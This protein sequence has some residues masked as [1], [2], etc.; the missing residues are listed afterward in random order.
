[1]PELTM[2]EAINL[3]LKQEMAADERVYVLGEDVGVDGGI[4]RAT[5]GLIEEFG[6]DRVMDTPLAESGI[7][8]FSIGMAING[9][10]PVPEMQFS[11]FAYLGFHQIESHASRMRWRSQGRF[12][13][14]MTVRMP[15]GGGVRALEHHSE[16]RE[17][18]YAHMPGVKMVV[19]SGPRNAR[20]LLVAAIRDPDPVVFFEPKASYRA[21][22]EEVP[23]DEEVAEIGPA[24]IVQEGQDLTIVSW[25]AMSR[26]AREA[27]SQLAE[28]DVSVELIDLTSLSPLDY[29]AIAK[30]VSRTG[31]C[32]VVQEAPLTY[33]P[34][35]EIAARVGEEAFLHLKAPVARVA[36]PDVHMPYFAREQAY[37]PDAGRIVQAAEYVRQ[38]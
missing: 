29:P 28:K 27:A 26:R 18:F 19:P 23:E 2:I 30:S 1:M 21:F 4:F 20:S 16:S 3:A 15:Y 9:L 35:A 24:Q 25:G 5:Q 17:A 14:P 37:L 8:G 11:G 13:I 22:R 7:L 10:R 33:G 6:E 34:A 12:G 31:R 32:V 38:F 36:G